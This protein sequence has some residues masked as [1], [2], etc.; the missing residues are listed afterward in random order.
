[1]SL[2][3]T[4]TNSIQHFD[5]I[6]IGAGCAGLSL[7]VRLATDEAFANKQILLLERAPKS[8][9]DRTWC[10]WENKPGYFDDI[11]HHRWND[12]WV[13]HQLGEK[14]L[15]LK[16]YAYK[17]IRGLDFYRHCFKI[18]SKAP[19]IKIH[20]GAVTNIDAAKGEVT[21]TDSVFT[22]EHI[23]SSVL[24]QQPELQPGEFYLLQHFRGWWIE[25]DTDFFIPEAADLMNFRTDQQHGC[26]FMYVLPV[27]K[28]KALVEYTLF[29]EEELESHLYDKALKSFI[30]NE[31]QL[32][33]YSI[34]EVEHGI[35]PMTNLR[36]P[37]QEGRITFIGTAG[38]QTKASSG[39][40]FQF[41]QKQSDAIVQALKQKRQ[42]D[43]SMPGR[44][45]FYDSVL[46]RVLHERKLQGADVFYKL[47]LSNPAPRVLSFLDNESNLWDEFC[48]MNSTQKSV[49]IPAAMAEW[50]R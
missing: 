6:I 21:S 23:F 9:N 24:L 44:F 12:L 8:L 43:F 5:Y 40:T 18:L 2:T 38:G 4:F 7:A 49:F 19:N 31:L 1:V 42:I 34:D 33:H 36:F 17:M 35:I 48:I 26:A 30:E 29:T 28:R 37:K 20:Y 27:S 50:R 47:F 45:R 16:G 39:Y 25:T 22:A 32:S 46:L 15:D 3:S 10:F 11:V 41:I 13:K 14:Q